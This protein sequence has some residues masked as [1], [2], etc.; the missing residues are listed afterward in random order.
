[1]FERLIQSSSVLH[2]VPLIGR[3]LARRRQALDMTRSGQDVALGLVAEFE[4][5]RRQPEYQR[6]FDDPKPLVSVCVGTYNRSDLLVSRCLRSLQE[7]TYDKLEII[8]VGDCCT[9]GTER[10]IEDLADP[11][12]RFENLPQRGPYP[13][14]PRLRWMVAG[15]MSVNRAMQLA[16]GAFITH[17]DDDDEHLPRRVELLLDHVRMQ[18]ADLVYHPFFWE[19]R[20]GR[21]TLNCATGFRHAQVTTS[22]VF[23]HSWL[24]RIQWDVDAWKYREPGDWNRFR[25]IQ[26]IGAKA[27]RHPEPLLRHYKER[28]QARR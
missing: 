19:K 1:M 22:S 20:P 23:Y 10:A 5:A 12:I 24:R 11:R 16:R 7:Q 18:R 2:D 28:A 13:E 21:W 15:T 17:L 8:V 3:E 6:A 14:D 27:V 26:F 25:K 4:R 9:D